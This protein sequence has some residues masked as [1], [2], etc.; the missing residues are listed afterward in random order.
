VGKPRRV[1]WALVLGGLI[2][3][4]VGDLS[5]AY[6]SALG[7]Q[8]RGPFVHATFILFYGLIAGGAHRQLQLLRS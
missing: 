7:Q 6:L 3:M 5:F 4:C 2:F 1:V 8:H